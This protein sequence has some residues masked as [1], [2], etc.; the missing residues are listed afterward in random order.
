MSQGFQ[1]EASFDGVRFDV[2][3]ASVSH[4]PNVA[5]HVYPKRDGANL[6]E[7]GRA[8]WTCTMEIV[9]F[10]RDAQPGEETPVESYEDRFQNFDFLVHDGGVRTLVH[11]YVGA[12]RAVITD[13][14]HQGTGDLEG[15]QA[16]VTFVEEISED[17]V[18][19][20]GAGATTT[21][22]S[23]EVLSSVVSANKAL[24]DQ[25]LE[26]ST[27]ADALTAAQNW[28]FDPE[29]S[30]RQVHSE[31]SQINNRLNEELTAFETGYGIASHPIMKQ[32]MLLQYN[33]R[34]AAD[35]FSSETARIVKINVTEP[36]PLRIIAARFYGAKTSSQR[37]QELIELNPNLTHPALVPAGAVIK[38]Y[39]RRSDRRRFAS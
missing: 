35:A 22:G 28:E 2:L 16:T 20:V 38:A 25:G 12:I 7:M 36:L 5:A 19:A 6:E 33:M 23:Q 4:G 26:S 3:S 34:R 14:S 9:F 11:P 13:F 21:A 29:L 31:M 10:D 17:P 15:I 37:L 32:Y 27:T 18:F 39:A 24:E 1:F 30:T 8:P